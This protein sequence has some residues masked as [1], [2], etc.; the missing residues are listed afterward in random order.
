M[1]TVTD[2]REA[3]NA[4]S[5]FLHNPERSQTGH[6]GTIRFLGNSYINSDTILTRTVIQT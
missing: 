4:A 2:S 3:A 5:R 6:F 1:C